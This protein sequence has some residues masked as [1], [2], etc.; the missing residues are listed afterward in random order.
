MK[1]ALICSD[2][3][4][5]QAGFMGVTSGKK[6]KNNTHYVNASKHL[7]VQK[8]CNNLVLDDGGCQM[9]AVES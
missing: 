6:Q 1:N 3:C 2:A 4:S 7:H 5:I 8:K 9:F